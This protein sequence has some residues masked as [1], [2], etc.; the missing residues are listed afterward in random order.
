MYR[1]DTI[2]A[3]NNLDI[4]MHLEFEVRIPNYYQ[5]KQ[6]N[7]IWDDVNLCQYSK[8]TIAVMRTLEDRE[9]SPWKNSRARNIAHLDSFIR[10]QI[11]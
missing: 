11:L 9:R 3:L 7:I 1:I 10:L 2:D 6:F 4:E 5:I 8:Q